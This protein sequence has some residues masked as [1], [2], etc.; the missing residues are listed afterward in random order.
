MSVVHENAEQMGDNDAWK[1]WWACVKYS[2]EAGTEDIPVTKI[3]EQ[4]KSK[5][6]KWKRKAFKPINFDD[7]VKEDWYVAWSSKDTVDNVE[8]PWFAL[9][10]RLAGE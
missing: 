10:G 4:Y 8:Q 9:I 2:N 7:F 5:S 6:G 3:K 1:N